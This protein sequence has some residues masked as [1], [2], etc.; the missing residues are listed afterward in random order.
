MSRQKTAGQSIQVISRAASILRLL[1]EDTDGLSLGQIAGRVD[2]PRSTVQRIVAALNAE[3]LVSVGQKAG[4]IQLGPAIRQLAGRS[5]QSDPE[6][7]RTALASLSDTTGETVDLAL[8][9]GH[10]M[11]FIDQIV[12]RQRLRAVS[13]AGEHFPLTNTA[14]G[15][16][17]LS[18]L[19]AAEQQ[20]LAQ[21]EL[22]SQ[23]DGTD[24]KWA[25]LKA[26][27]AEITQTNIAFDRDEHT[28]G[29]SAA[30]IAVAD[31]QGRIYALSIPVPSARF[32]RH[33]AFF[34]EQLLAWHAALQG[35]LG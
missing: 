26:E 6:I 20:R 33:Q 23:P 14:N 1:G 15:K 35:Q 12:G 19:P 34:E 28:E 4:K 24:R 9:D 31:S 11:L 32:T 16:A 10:S 3:Q 8:F 13:E 18:L 22:A 2:L 5:S 21:K 7:L 27:L 29:I 25:A 30:G 17:A